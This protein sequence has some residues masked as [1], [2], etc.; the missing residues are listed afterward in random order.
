LSFCYFE[1]TLPIVNH[2]GK[3]YQN[4]SV[5]DDYRVIRCWAGAAPGGP[6]AFAPSLALVPAFAGMTLELRTGLETLK[7]NAILLEMAE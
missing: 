6:T 3:A 2:D 7:P 5:I 4:D 1:I